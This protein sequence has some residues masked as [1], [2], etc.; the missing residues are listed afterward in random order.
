MLLAEVAAAAS[1]LLH[2]DRVSVFVHDERAGELW[3]RVAGGMPELRVPADKGL[4][5]EA[6]RTARD[7]AGA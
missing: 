4:V 6:L 2:A 3:A 5:G 7:G 1:E